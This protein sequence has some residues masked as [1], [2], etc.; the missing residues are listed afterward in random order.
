MTAFVALIAA[1]IASSAYAMY[2]KHDSGCSVSEA[3]KIAAVVYCACLLSFLSM[4]T[5]VGR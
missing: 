3:A 1:A 4:T 2:I 5:M